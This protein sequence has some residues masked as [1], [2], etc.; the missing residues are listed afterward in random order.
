MPPKGWL[1]FHIFQYL[2]WFL[3]ISAI[4]DG[5]N[6]CKYVF[7]SGAFAFITVLIPLGDFDIQYMPHSVA[8]AYV[9]YFSGPN[10]SGQIMK[11]AAKKW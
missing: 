9:A 1:I 11:S 5:Q 7:Q 10:F 3:F 8:A 6:Q 4:A 2:L